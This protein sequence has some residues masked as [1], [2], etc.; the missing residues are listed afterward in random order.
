MPNVHKISY[1]WPGQQ[2]S[3]PQLPELAGMQGKV[4]L[5]RHL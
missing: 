1:P 5:L 4:L 3:L 2:I